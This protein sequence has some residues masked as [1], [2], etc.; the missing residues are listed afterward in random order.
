MPEPKWSEWWTNVQRYR[1]SIGLLILVALTALHGWAQQANPL[2]D[3]E[4]RRIGEKLRCMCGGCNYTLG[5]CNMMSCSGAE[6]GRAKLKAL[7]DEGLTEDQ[8][9]AAFVDEFGPQVL[10]NPPAEGFN[11][12]GWLM[13]FVALVFG[14][15][16][17]AWF[18]KR[19]TGEKTPAA[20]PIPV[21]DAVL[22]RYQAQIE[23]DLANMD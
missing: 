9:L 10:T 4:V 15:V 7:V 1:R 23:K 12:V 5:S 20:A 17:L 2:T 3:P 21:D 11:L 8:I 16:I 14:M 22:E 18:V 13:P 19:Y 6:Y